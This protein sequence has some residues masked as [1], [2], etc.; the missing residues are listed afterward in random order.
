MLQSIF[1]YINMLM[2]F[3]ELKK[4]MPILDPVTLTKERPFL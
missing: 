4:Q 2:N 1:V 3:T